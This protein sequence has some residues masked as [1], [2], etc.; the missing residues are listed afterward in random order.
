[1]IHQAEAQLGYSHRLYVHRQAKLLHPCKQQRFAEVENAN[2]NASIVRR[3]SKP[4]HCISASSYDSLKRRRINSNASLVR[5]KSTRSC[6]VRE[7][8]IA[9][10]DW[11][12][13]PDIHVDD[14]ITIAVMVCSELR[15]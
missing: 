1:M 3:K 2:P 5:G 9:T 6:E 15:T 13:G 8:P 11:A 4:W 12:C 7:L 14:N 10:H